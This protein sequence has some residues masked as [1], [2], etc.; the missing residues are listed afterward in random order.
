MPSSDVP[1]WGVKQVASAAFLFIA[2]AIGLQAAHG[3]QPLLGGDPLVAAVL[4]RNFDRAK[5]LLLAG[6]PPQGRDTDGRPLTV[7]AIANTDVRTLGLLLSYGANPNETDRRGN[8][9][10][11]QAAA[12]GNI[13][14]VNLLIDAGARINNAN[15]QGMTPLMRAAEAGAI[16]V[17]RRLL[18]AGATVD[19]TDFTGRDALSWAEIN[20]H[21]R[22]ATILRNAGV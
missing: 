20:G 10:L 2:L 3:Q 4:D 17:I 1:R 16:G 8:G 5:A 22:A 13:D 14:A 9:P 19:A 12:L 7:I 15:Q 6:T 21:E 11:S 18:E